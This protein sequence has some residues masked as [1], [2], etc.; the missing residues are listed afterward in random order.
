MS[1]GAILIML[2]AMFC[3]SCW[4]PCIVLQR[5]GLVGGEKARTPLPAFFTIPPVLRGPRVKRRSS[6]Q[7]VGDVLGAGVCIIL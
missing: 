2:L 6:G 4:P 3:F 1:R 5:Y 7:V